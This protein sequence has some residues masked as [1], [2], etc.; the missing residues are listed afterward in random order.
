ME[1]LRRAAAIVLSLSESQRGRE[2]YSRQR[3]AHRV[4]CAKFA[5]SFRSPA[6]TLVCWDAHNVSTCR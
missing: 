3:A 5:G 2:R 6:A 4:D 1:A